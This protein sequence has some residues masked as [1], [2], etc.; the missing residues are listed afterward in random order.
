MR[1]KSLV[2]TFLTLVVAG[3][4]WYISHLRAPETDI[5]T[6]PLYPGLSARVND[7]TRA[8]VASRSNKVAL[9]RDGDTWVIEDLDGYPAR[10]EDVKRAILSVA[11]LK[12]IE[13][14]TKLPEMYPHIGVEDIAAENSASTSVVFKDAAG[15]TLA[16]L[17]V[18]K[19]RAATSGPIK[20]ARYVRKNGEPQAYLVEGD[21]NISADPISWTTRELLSIAATRIREISIEHPGKPTVTMRREKPED[22]DLLLQDIPDGFKT[23]SAATVTSLA[24]ALEALR[25]DHVRAKSAVQW[26][27]DSTVTTLRGIDGLLATVRTATAG[28]RTYS[29]FVFAFD[30]SAVS[31]NAAAAAQTNPASPPTIPLPG[32]EDAPSKEPPKVSVAEEVE[33]L[34]GRVQG[35]VYV[36][37]DYKQS[38]L[39]RTLDDLIAKKEDKKPPPAPLPPSDPLKVESFDKDGKPLLPDATPAPEAGLPMPPVNSDTAAES[40][41]PQAPSIDAG[42]PAEAASSDPDNTPGGEP[43]IPTEESAVNPA[44]DDTS[45]PAPAGPSTATP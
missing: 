8:E 45:A 25:F 43:A 38:M 9:V 13:P 15:Q 5:G 18:G 7:V 42:A 3:A 35:W 10:F 31:T 26:P 4:A 22:I 2:Y 12:I 39:T 32:S 1:R 41:A 36:L 23:K 11:E 27:A 17:I 14:K 16:S 19:Q 28:D 37:P 6:A 30:S 24:T 33:A 44:P 20:A 34:N 21:L 29:E 40:A